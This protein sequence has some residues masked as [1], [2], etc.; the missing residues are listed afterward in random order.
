MIKIKSWIWNQTLI[1]IDLKCRFRIRIETNADPKLWLIAPR[2]GWPG[3]EETRLLT[4][5]SH[6]VEEEKDQLLDEQGE[7][8]AIDGTTVD[9]LHVAGAI[10]FHI[11]Q[12]RIV[13]IPCALSIFI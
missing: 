12:Y 2:E 11:E 10:L 5:G 1:G 6:R 4:A 9:I 7:D 3:W 8:D 13:A